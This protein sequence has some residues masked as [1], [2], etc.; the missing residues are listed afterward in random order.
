G[1]NQ[2]ELPKNSSSKLSLNC[3]KRSRSM[4]AENKRSRFATTSASSKSSK[5]RLR[6][7]MARAR[8]RRTRSRHST[9]RRE[10]NRS[11]RRDHRCLSS[12]RTQA[13]GHQYPLRPV[14]RRRA[15]PEIQRRRRR[16]TRKTFG[17]RNQRGLATEYRSEPRV[18]RNAQENAERL[19]QPSNRNARGY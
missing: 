18:F 6:N 15:R 7:R 19:S 9:T 17:R 16:A 4:A 11:G 3:H 5:L 2:T 8:R 13:A 12:R 1:L 14:P 10:G